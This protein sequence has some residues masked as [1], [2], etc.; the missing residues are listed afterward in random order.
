VHKLCPWVTLLAEAH[1]FIITRI[2]K[3]VQKNNIAINKDMDDSTQLKPKV[4]IMTFS[5][6]QV[7]HKLICMYKLQKR[8]L[9]NIFLYL[10]A[11]P[12]AL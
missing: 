1:N 12:F 9:P 6:T 7:S 3:S 5:T 2:M 10:Q 4:T 11:L 8:E